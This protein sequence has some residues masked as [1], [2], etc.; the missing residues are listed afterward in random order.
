[1]VRGRGVAADGVHV[2]AVGRREHARHAARHPRP[3]ASGGVGFFFLL[4]TMASGHDLFLWLCKLGCST[5]H[6]SI[7]AFAE[8]V[9]SPI[10]SPVHTRAVPWTSRTAP[11]VPWGLLCTMASAGG[12]FL[13]LFQSGPL[14]RS[15]RPP[16]SPPRQPVVGRLGH[17]RPPIRSRLHGT[18]R[19]RLRRESAWQLAQFLLPTAA[20]QPTG[21]QERAPRPGADRAAGVAP[22]PN[23]ALVPDASDRS[24]LRH[25]RNQ[26]LRV[27]SWPP[28]G[29]SYPTCPTVPRSG[30]AEISR[31]EWFLGRLLDPTYIFFVC[32][33]YCCF[34]CRCH[35]SGRPEHMHLRS[36]CVPESSHR[37]HSRRRPVPHPP[38]PSCAIHRTTLH[39]L[40]WSRVYENYP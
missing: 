23:P 2:D 36:P 12:L 8:A 15:R 38:Y 22:T 14:S 31:F 27:A 28:V 5:E 39:T 29:Y 30:T 17:R 35:P 18:L 3:R 40:I 9:G 16:P 1:M 24:P 20:F 25:R 7:A 4:C 21:L 19:P 6:P 10:P 32:C 33:S 37:W 34:F 13:W 26:P 11:P